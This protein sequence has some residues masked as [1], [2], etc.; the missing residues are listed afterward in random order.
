MTLKEYPFALEDDVV[1]TVLGRL[2]PDERLSPIINE[3]LIQW[4]IKD[5]SNK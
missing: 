3:L 4:I 2:K 5:E 1:E